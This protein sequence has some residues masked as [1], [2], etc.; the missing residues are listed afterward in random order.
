[1]IGDQMSKKK[2][3]T[4]QKAAIKPQK[5]SKKP[6][7]VA[8]SAIA[9]LVI[10]A[11]IAV[12]IFINSSAKDKLA[13][14][15]WIPSSA[16]SAS[17]DEVEMIDVYETNYTAYQGSLSFN[18]DGTFNF[19]LTPGDPNDGTHSGKY[20]LSD[21]KSKI[22]AEFDN[23]VTTE[24]SIIRDNGDISYISVDYNGYKVQF[25]KN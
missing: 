16:K 14:T 17:G 7:F 3:N 24:F 22:N 25:V 10:A 1:M 9:V 2:N 21:D 23:G 12:C 11:V 5:K 6:L 20:T 19:W 15:S 13:D 8:L 18:D 4:K